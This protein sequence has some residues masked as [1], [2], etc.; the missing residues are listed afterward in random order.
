[1]GVQNCIIR[2]NS[3][4]IATQ[5]EKE[6]IAID[7]TLE[8]YLALIKRTKNDFKGFSVE[9]IKRSKNIEADKLAKATAQGT[10]L[11]LDVFF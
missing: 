5:I 6:C 8:K 11:P 4:V 10:T 3:K 2:T 7:T 9:H 1:M